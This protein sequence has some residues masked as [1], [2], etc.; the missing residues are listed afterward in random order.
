MKITDTLDHLLRLLLTTD[1]D[2]QVNEEASSASEPQRRTESAEPGSQRTLPEWVRR[3]NERVLAAHG[4]ARPAPES[5]PDQA[6]ASSHAVGEQ[7]DVTPDV[8][9]V[10]EPVLPSPEADLAPAEVEVLASDLDDTDVGTALVPVDQDLAHLETAARVA[11]SLGLGF[12]LGSAVERIASAANQGSEG[13]P[14]LREAAWL[15][16]RYV[17]ILEQRPIGANLHL[18]AA[19]LARA[20]DAIAGLKALA[21]A[22]DADAAPVEAEQ[23]VEPEPPAMAVAD[24]V[25]AADG[26]DPEPD[27]WSAGRIRRLPP[28]PPR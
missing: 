8:P 17:A 27:L 12:H 11:E 23:P 5:A 20:G 21:E 18:S 10:V 22:L 1:E 19:R 13:V 6:A 28:E 24:V 16:E 25:V 15:I 4:A 26:P 14:A 2:G 3:A 7:P 9:M